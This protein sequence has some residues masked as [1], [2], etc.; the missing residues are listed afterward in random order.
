M[1]FRATSGNGVNAYEAWATGKGASDEKPFT[2]ERSY[3][4]HFRHRYL[5]NWSNF[6]IKYVK[7]ALYDHDREVAYIIFNGVGSGINNWFSKT[8]VI[9]SSYSDLTPSATYS[10]F[11]IEGSH[12][13]RRFLIATY[14]GCDG[15]T[16]HFATIDNNAG[17]LCLWDNHPAYPQFL[18]SMVNKADYFNRR[19]F[20]R[21]DY[22]AVFIKKT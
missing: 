7:F 12:V 14:A 17:T 16:V 13:H 6:D 4:S 9:A 10:Q 5:D 21:A 1:V 15:D 19:Q 18:Y 3:A 2:M 20:G 11:S 22:L 8:R